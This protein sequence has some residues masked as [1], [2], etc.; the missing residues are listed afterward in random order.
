M[1]TNLTPE[2]KKQIEQE[3]A[4]YESA[5]QHE[6]LGPAIYADGAIAY[7]ECWQTAEADKVKLNRMLKSAVDTG[8]KAIE[9]AER[10]EKALREIQAKAKQGIFPHL[11][12]ETMGA[13]M[14]IEID[15]YITE[16]FTH[17]TSTGDTVN[18]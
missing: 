14:C 11:P 6:G 10:Y 17:K 4:K 1:T 3:A 9:R 16:L 8:K 15:R 7:A 18:G 13:Q 5:T 12:V 2:L